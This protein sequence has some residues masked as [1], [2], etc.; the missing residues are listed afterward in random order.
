RAGGTVDFLGLARVRLDGDRGTQALARGVD[1]R[2]DA[3]GH[4]HLEAVRD[5]SL[6]SWDVVAHRFVRDRGRAPLGDGLSL[7]VAAARGDRGGIRMRQVFAISLLCA[8]ASVATA[9]DINDYRRGIELDVK[10]KK[11]LVELDVP[12]LVYRTVMRADLGDVRVFNAE[13]QPVPHTL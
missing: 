2:S 8:T 4:R 3:D 6:G 9:A 7:A 13:G 10:E 12:D 1:R 11:P 5:R